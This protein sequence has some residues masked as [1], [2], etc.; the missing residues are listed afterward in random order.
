MKPLATIGALSPGGLTLP[1]ALPTPG[2]LYGPRGVFFDG[3]N[4]VVCDTGNHRV[5]IFRNYDFSSQPSADVV[6]GQPDFYCE[7]HTNGGPER[8]LFM[9]TGVAIH[10]GQLLVAD[11]WH[12]RVLVWETL[13]TKNWQGANR[14]IGQPDMSGI[15]PNQGASCSPT[16]LYWPFGIGFAAGRFWIADT[17]NRRLLGFSEVPRAHEQPE[18]IIGQPDGFSHDENRGELGARSFR[19]VHDIAGDERHLYV[20]DAGN[21]RI[22]HWLGDGSG[23]INASSVIGQKDLMSSVEWP[24]G[25]HSSQS[26]RFPYSISTSNGRMAIADTAN[27]RVLLYKEIPTGDFGAADYVLGQDSFATNGENH[28]IEVSDDSMC[29]PFAVHLVGD[30]LFVADTGNN[31]VVIWDLEW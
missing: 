29:W 9:P 5:L 4:L 3:E 6:I 11:A 8:G 17:G 30:R 23:D 28:W 16:S 12:H 24:Y 21:H 1:L 31:R 10:D 7:T 2:Q 26:L 13:P 20:S 14:A 27:N 19:W 15:E 25:P 22:L 18:V